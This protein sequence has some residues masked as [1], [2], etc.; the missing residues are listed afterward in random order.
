MAH[1]FLVH[2]SVAPLHDPVFE[3]IEQRPVQFAEQSGRDPMRRDPRPN[4]P[5]CTSE[6]EVHARVLRE[7]LREPPTAEAAIVSAP[8]GQVPL[9]LP[10]R[11]SEP[12]D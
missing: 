7:L 10:K 6:N 3:H 1:L 12:S 5:M 4:E 8:D 9:L 2:Q 11:Q